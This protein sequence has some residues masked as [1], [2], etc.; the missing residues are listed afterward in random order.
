MI[1]PEEVNDKLAYLV[2]DGGLQVHEDRPGHV[3]PGAGLR[4]EGV[5]GV[6]ASSN[7]LVRWHLNEE[8][9][10]KTIY[11]SSSVIKVLH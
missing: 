8:E 11:V 7:S 3:L 6:I 10:V 5:K 1:G 9:I 2:N 4:E